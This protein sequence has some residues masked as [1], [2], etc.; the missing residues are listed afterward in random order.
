MRCKDLKDSAKV[1]AKV[2]GPWVPGYYA[3]LRGTQKR[4]DRLHAANQ[5]QAAKK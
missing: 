3:L 2:P 1:L 5:S 4:R